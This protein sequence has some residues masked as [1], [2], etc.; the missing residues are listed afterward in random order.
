MHKIF[1]EIQVARINLSKTLEARLL[2]RCEI[3]SKILDRKRT[4]LLNS[5][6]EWRQQHEKEAEK[7]V[8]HNSELLV[9]LSLLCLTTSSY[10]N[11]STGCGIGRKKSEDEVG[12]KV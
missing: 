8:L 5:F 1:G 7:L 6:N 4:R 10:F 3:C 12:E 2:N 9:G 11:F